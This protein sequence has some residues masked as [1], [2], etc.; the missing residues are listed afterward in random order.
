MSNIDNLPLQVEY[1]YSQAKRA[2]QKISNLCLAC[3]KSNIKTE[4]QRI[5]L[6][7]VTKP[8]LLNG[9]KYASK[10]VA[11]ARKRWEVRIGKLSIGGRIDRF[12]K[13]RSQDGFQYA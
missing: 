7:L 1:F 3:E 5:E 8:D 13:L 10:V 9:V 12:V 2:A 6:F 11:R 4:T